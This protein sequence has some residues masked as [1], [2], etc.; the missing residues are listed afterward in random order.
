VG[1]VF[2]LISPMMCLSLTSTDEVLKADRRHEGRTDE[3]LDV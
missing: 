2:S 1:L 3:I